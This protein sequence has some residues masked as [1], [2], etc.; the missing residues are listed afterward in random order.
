VIRISCDTF[1]SEK[2]SKQ[3]FSNTHIWVTMANTKWAFTSPVYYIITLYAYIHETMP[4]LF[5]LQHKELQPLHSYGYSSNSQVLY[6]N[7]SE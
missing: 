1:V 2:E 6:F 7:K 3:K 5:K 4:L